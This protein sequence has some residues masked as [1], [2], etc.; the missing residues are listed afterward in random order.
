L[1]GR[2]FINMAS[3]YDWFQ[4]R[5]ELQAIADDV[6]TKYV[7]P[8]V[9]IFYCLGGIT[10]T[11]FVVQVATGFALTFFYR[12]SVGEAFDSV[13]NLS[14][15]VTGGWLLR[16]MHQWSA[17]LM[18]VFLLLH[19]TRVYLTGGF[20]APRE[21]TWLTGVILAFLVVS[22]GV[23]GYT[24]PWDQ[25]GYW[26]CVIVTGVPS[27]LPGGEILVRGL[28]GAASVGQGTLSR[29]Y[30]VHTLVLPLA[31]VLSML[32]HFLMIRKQGI[33]GPL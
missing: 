18:V 17:T 1:I 29:Y 31:A 3:I 26:A 22:F 19:V 15:N 30:T 21:M 7:P 23:T 27:V 4:E 28:R 16:S 9:N 10:L 11:S 2:N 20:K 5:I 32:V 12:P 6:T 25:I 14:S 13:E 8:H 24:L 33:S